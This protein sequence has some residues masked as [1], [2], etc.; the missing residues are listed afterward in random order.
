MGWSYRKSFA[1]DC[2]LGTSQLMTYIFLE[3]LKV[4]ADMPRG[5][6]LA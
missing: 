4:K 5:P 1:L 2:A 3:S 6:H